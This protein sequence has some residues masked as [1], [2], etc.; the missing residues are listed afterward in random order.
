MLAT[1]LRGAIRAQHHTDSVWLVLQVDRQCQPTL[2]DQNFT[3]YFLKP[4]LKSSVFLRNLGVTG[5][6]EMMMDS[7]SYTEHT[8]C[9][10]LY[11]SLCMH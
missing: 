10:T 2:E 1:V 6:T 11:L 3:L 5:L 9:Q 4:I 8:V 7:S